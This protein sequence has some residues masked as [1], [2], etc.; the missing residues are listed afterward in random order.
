MLVRIGLALLVVLA[1]APAWGGNLS[2]KAFSGKWQGSAVSESDI[3]VHFRLTSRDIDVE[4]RPSAD[5]FNITWNTVQRQKGDPRNPKEKLKST[6][7]VFTAQRP[8][9]W[10]STANGDPLSKETP[11]AWAHIIEKSLIITVLQIYADG[12]HEIQIYRRTLSGLGM[13]LDFTRVVNGEAVRRA[14]GRLVKVAN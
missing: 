9:V 7:M 1:A 2:L 11:Y 10:R 6:S 12:R 5:G 8:G 3:S 4:I 13:R 14:D